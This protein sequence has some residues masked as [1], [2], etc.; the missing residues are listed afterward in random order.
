MKLPR[1][2]HQLYA[3]AMGYFWLPCPICGR[4]FGGHEWRDPAARIQ[5][6][7]G[8]GIGV[9]DACIPEAKRLSE[10]V[11]AEETSIKHEA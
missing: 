5:L 1:W 2:I 9:C 7:G 4:Y 8:R 10:L 6:T 3:L 11:Y